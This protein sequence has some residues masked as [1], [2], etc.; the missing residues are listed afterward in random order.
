MSWVVLS[1]Q[2]V[3]V[4]P[5]SSP[6]SRKEALVR[7]LAS[8][9]VAAGYVWEEFQ[10]ALAPH[11]QRLLLNFQAGW[12]GVAWSVR[13][14]VDLGRFSPPTA[15][16]P[17]PTAPLGCYLLSLSRLRRTLL[18]LKTEPSQWPT[19]IHA[20]LGPSGGVFLDPRIELRSDVERDYHYHEPGK[21]GRWAR[22]LDYLFR[23]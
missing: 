11:H 14:P 15:P 13:G 5:D 7:L 22:G 20:G 17:T 18:G 8:N 6:W 2:G 16:G 10:S 3:Q 12:E 21:I 1:E 4:L 19:Q 9:V 23:E